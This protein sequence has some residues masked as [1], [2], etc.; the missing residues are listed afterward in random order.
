VTIFA[1]VN[2]SSNWAIAAANVCLRADDSSSFDRV[3]RLARRSRSLNQF[4][5]MSSI[6]TA[7]LPVVPEGG[8]R[9]AVSQRSSQFVTAC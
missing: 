3:R 9:L 8:T 6:T 1:A 4:M 2:C 5:D 7:P